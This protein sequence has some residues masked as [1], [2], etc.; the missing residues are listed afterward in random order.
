MTLR[1]HRGTLVGREVVRAEVATKGVGPCIFLGR[2]I[3]GASAGEDDGRSFSTNESTLNFALPAFGSFF[4]HPC[5][6]S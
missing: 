5:G 2:G 1:N 3:Q 4:L 6:Q